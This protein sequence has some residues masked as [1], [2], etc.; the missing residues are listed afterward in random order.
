MMRIL[1]IWMCLSVSAFAVE[2]DEMLAD[3]VLEARAQALDE[4][5]RCVK[6]QSES[7][8][9]SNAAWA[10]TAR[11][12]VRER[13]SAGES[14]ADVVAYFVERY[15][16]HVRMQPK[17]GGA[18][19]LLWLSGPFLLLAGVGIAATTLR[20]RRAQATTLSADEQAELDALLA[21]EERG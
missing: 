15:G 18:T 14:D 11:I 19:L 10:K 16:E 20:S 1:L 13:L 7:I 5:I 8:A 17:F 9:S 6:C 3:P 2:P 12:I 21:N 4:Q